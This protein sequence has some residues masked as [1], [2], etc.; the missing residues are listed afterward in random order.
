MLQR[1]DFFLNNLRHKVLWLNFFSQKSYF[2]KSMT[3]TTKLFVFCHLRE[4][5]YL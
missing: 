3:K 2:E 1:Y 5:C 4:N